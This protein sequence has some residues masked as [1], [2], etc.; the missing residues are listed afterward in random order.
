MAGRVSKVKLQEMVDDINRKCGYAVDAYTKTKD[1]VKSNH[2]TYLLDDN[3]FYGGMQLNQ[4]CENGGIQHVFSCA[5][6]K[7]KEMLQLL[8]GILMGIE[9]GKKM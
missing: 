3:P 4:M 2:G 1:G 5:R 9:L 8:Q 7:P 6:I